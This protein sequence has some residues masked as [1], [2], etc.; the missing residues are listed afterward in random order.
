MSEA[1]FSRP[2]QDQASKLD[3]EKTKDIR[4][5]NI[6]AA[7]GKSS[8]EPVT[9]ANRGFWM[10]N[11]M[12]YDWDKLWINHIWRVNTNLTVFPQKLKIEITLTQK[13]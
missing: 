13:T 3:S 8:L 2:N 4:S 5:T 6:I 9:H 12:D 11:W 10:E 1:K 7:K